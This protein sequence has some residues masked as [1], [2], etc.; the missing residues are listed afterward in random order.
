MT[1]ARPLLFVL[2]V[3]CV[4]TSASA[5]GDGSESQASAGSTQN[6]TANTALF[7]QPAT[8]LPETSEL[9]FLKE[10][11]RLDLSPP[12]VRPQSAILTDEACLTLRMYK[13]KRKEH[14]ADGETG[15]RG[16]TTCELASN[17]QVRSAVAHVR[18][19]QENDAPKN[20]LHK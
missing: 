16:Y 7:S 17:Y 8:G 20:E 13:V 3:V 6:Q 1:S 14:F 2:L 5:A 9:F 10:R 12:V 11:P 4:A 15:F 19:L 18:T